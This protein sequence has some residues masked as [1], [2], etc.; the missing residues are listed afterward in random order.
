VNIILELAAVFFATFFL[1][2]GMLNYLDTGK[3]YR[4]LPGHALRAILWGVVSGSIA[5]IIVAA[6]ILSP[7]PTP[8]GG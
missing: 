8:I 2:V 3:V 7:V 5:V 6:I 4:M 1:D